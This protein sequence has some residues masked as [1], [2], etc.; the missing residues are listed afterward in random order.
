MLLAAV[1]SLHL[2]PGAAH[3]RVLFT[4][5][6][7][8]LDDAAGNRQP[9]LRATVAGEETL[10]LLDTGA[11]VHLLLAG[12]AREAGGRPAEQAKVQDHAGEHF[13]TQL[14]AE[15][16]IKVRGKTV[17]LQRVMDMPSS[18]GF[19]K[20]G[21]GGVLS[22]QTMQPGTFAVM[23]HPS[24]KVTLVQGTLEDAEKVLRRSLPG[25]TLVRTPNLAQEDDLVVVEATVEGG[26]PAP[27]LVDTGA[28]PVE[29][30]AV[31][32]GVDVSGGL[33]AP[34]QSATGT[35]V[36][37]I[38][39]QRSVWLAGRSFPATQVLAR[40]S[41]GTRAYKALLGMDLLADVGLVV[42]ARP[43]PVA[44]AIP[45]EPELKKRRQA[46]ADRAARET[47]KRVEDLSRD[48]E[49]LSRGLERN[50]DETARSMQMGE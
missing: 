15:V 30:L 2:V 41:M 20:L 14:W 10:L 25:W 40:P 16:P 48:L 45:P 23:D 28:M 44:L 33:A 18:D 39:V 17:R 29:C 8:Y 42:G 36:L 50:M 13:D 12:L 7:A 47:K 31:L 5:P 4:A 6:M 38:P 27:A 21:V 46:R 1:T 3:G 9:F 43:A 32:A 26:A 22:P 24:G 49:R 35:L 34:S 19:K 11:S 37:G